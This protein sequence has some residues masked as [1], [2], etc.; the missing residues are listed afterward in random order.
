MGNHTS[1]LEGLMILTGSLVGAGLTALLFD[2]V[3]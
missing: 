2:W 1:I 3:I